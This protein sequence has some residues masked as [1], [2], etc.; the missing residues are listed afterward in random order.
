MHSVLQQCKMRAC[1]F[2]YVCTR[3]FHQNERTDLLQSKFVFV[4]ESRLVP[5]HIRQVVF[6]FSRYVFRSDSK[7]KKIPRTF[8]CKRDSVKI[9][10]SFVVSKLI[11]TGTRNSH[12]IRA[13]SRT[14]YWRRRDRI[15]QKISFEISSCLYT[16]YIAFAYFGVFDT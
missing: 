9:D 13:T 14:L 16:L 8:A 7:K 11:V 3:K 15:F 12:Q 10:Y 5:V 2:F 1:V 4:C 6:R